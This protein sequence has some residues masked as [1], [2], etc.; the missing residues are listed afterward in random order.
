MRGFD[1][2]EGLMGV[3]GFGGSGLRALRGLKEVYT[4]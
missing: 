3:E 2:I 4:R 1:R